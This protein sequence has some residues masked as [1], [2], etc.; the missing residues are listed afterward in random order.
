MISDTCNKRQSHH[1]INAHVLGLPK[2]LR[3]SHDGVDRSTQTFGIALPGAGFFINGV[4]SGVLS[5]ASIIVYT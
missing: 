4:R 2:Q 3:T 1:T 5:L